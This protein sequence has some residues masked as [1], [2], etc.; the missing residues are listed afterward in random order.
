M[1]SG[2][3]GGDFDHR[4]TLMRLRVTDGHGCKVIEQGTVRSVFI[5]VRRR[6]YLCHPWFDWTHGGGC[7]EV[8]EEVH[9]AY[10]NNTLSASNLTISTTV[11]PR[12]LLLDLFGTDSIA[13][14][15]QY[16]E[17]QRVQSTQNSYTFRFCGKESPYF[18]TMSIEWVR[19][20]PVC[21]KRRVPK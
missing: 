6:R 15:I 3:T 13:S 11:P 1:S 12:S 17:P 19:R 9:S 5:R 2:K 21:P 4:C 8:F 16:C 20:P 18:V 10:F 7:G 14:A